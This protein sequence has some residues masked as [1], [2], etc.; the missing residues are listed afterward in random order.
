[1]SLRRL[2]GQVLDDERSCVACDAPAVAEPYQTTLPDKVAELRKAAVT[3]ADLA[4]RKAAEADALEAEIE[5]AQPHAFLRGGCKARLPST[6]RG[7]WSPRGA[8]SVGIPM[9]G[10]LA[11]APGSPAEADTIARTLAVLTPVPEGAF[12]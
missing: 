10:R 1:M 9:G 8:W 4:K 11:D 2:G 7:P 5:A 12:Q 6:M 3:C